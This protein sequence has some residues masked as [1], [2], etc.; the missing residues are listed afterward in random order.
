LGYIMPHYLAFLPD[1]RHEEVR[2]L[3][4]QKQAWISRP[5]KGFLRYLEPM[6]AVAHLRASSLDLAGDAVR[7]GSR[8]DLSG[9]EHEQMLRLLKNFMPWRKGPFSVF[10][11]EIDSEW[12]S[13]RK[14]NRLLPELPDLQGKIVADIGCGN[15]YYM[16]RTAAHS[17]KLVLGFEPYVHHYFT[18]SALN[19]FAGQDNLCIDL[20]GIEH[21]TLFPDCFDLIFCLGVLYH[22]P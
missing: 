13:Q 21:L 11:I 4:A 7:I 1:A 18:F 16:F 9:C 19:R 8:S 14:W 20:L 5:K 10:G 12:R 6:A 3:H 2:R 22:R 17:P 15:G